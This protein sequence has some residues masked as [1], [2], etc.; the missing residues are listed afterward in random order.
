L[1]FYGFVENN[2]KS[3]YGLRDEAQFLQ[4]SNWSQEGN[5][6]DALKKVRWVD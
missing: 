2:G 1:G 5:H 3:R 6:F 4:R